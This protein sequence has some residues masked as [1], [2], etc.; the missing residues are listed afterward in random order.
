MKSLT[1]IRVSVSFAGLPTCFRRKNRRVVKNQ[2]FPNLQNHTK[3]LS[4]TGAKVTT[5]RA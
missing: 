3:D 5:E 2:A 4:S 1:L